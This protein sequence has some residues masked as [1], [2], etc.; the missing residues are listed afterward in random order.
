MHMFLWMGLAAVAT[1]ERA[2]FAFRS[3]TFNICL[4]STSGLQQ[5]AQM[6]PWLATWLP[7]AVAMFVKEPML[8]S[9]LNNLWA[10]NVMCDHFIGRWNGKWDP[11][12]RKERH[13]MNNYL[14]CHPEFNV[15]Y[16][17]VE[18]AYL[19]L[20]CSNYDGPNEQS[21]YTLFLSKVSMLRLPV[22]RTFMPLV[23]NQF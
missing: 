11:R 12:P 16:Y 22:I 10:Q 20:V 13:R 5:W 21:A 23:N 2:C 6:F 18:L 4:C 1:S 14:T 8:E 15:F 9:L 19:L 7:S 17:S 3:S